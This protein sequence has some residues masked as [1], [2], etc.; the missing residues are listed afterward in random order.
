[1]DNKKI[2]QGFGLACCFVLSNLSQAQNFALQNTRARTMDGEYIS[3][4][5]H[6]IDDQASSG[7][8]LRGSDGLIF[9]DLDGDGHQDII[10][11]HESDDRYDGVPEGHIRIAF[12]SEDPD[13]W[14]SIT[15]AEGAEAGAAEDVAA[16]DVDGDGDLDLVAACELSHLLYLENPG[17]DIRNPQA[18]QRLIPSITTNRGSFI[19]VFLADLN[20]D[21]RPEVLSPNKGSQN[22]ELVRQQP[23]P[24]SYFEIQ[25]DPLD[26]SAWVEHKLI[27]FPWP[28]NARP[29]DLDG[30]GDLDVVGGSVAERR[31]LWFENT[32]RYGRFSFLTHSIDLTKADPQAPDLTLH[33][34]NMDFTDFNADGRLDILTL[35]TPPLLGRRLLWLE[36]PATPDQAWRYHLIDDWNPDSIVGLKLADIDGDGDQDIMAGGYSLSSRLDDIPTPEGALGRLAW[37]QNKGDGTWTGHPFSRRQRG[38]FDKFLARDMDGDGDMDFVGTRGNSGPYDGVFWLEQI[39]TNSPV[40]AFKQA[41]ETDSP[42][43]PLP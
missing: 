38:M 23:K 43:V 5:E 19:R 25:G 28:I 14:E 15:I 16:A 24:I 7:I 12:G 40:P 31:M 18:W 10:S 36:Q 32:S 9:A 27:E 33:S 42:E 2:R 21:G 17:S 20:G 37:Y 4:R 22:P 8:E 3:W 6:I 26:D 11:V 41:R 34:F 1:M 29:V 13:R 30:D 39:R 35:D